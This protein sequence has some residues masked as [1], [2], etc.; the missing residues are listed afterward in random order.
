MLLTEIRSSVCGTSIFIDKSSDS[1]VCDSTSPVNITLAYI[2]I[3]L[4]EHLYYI[5]VISLLYT[6][7]CMEFLDLAVQF[8]HFLIDC[9]VIEFSLVGFGKMKYGGMGS[10][11]GTGCVALI[12]YSNNH[13][14][15]STE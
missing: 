15:C 10:E 1:L 13:T 12:R 14:R 8:F 5:S 6:L 9:I 2:H 7:A 4:F 3:H 11:V